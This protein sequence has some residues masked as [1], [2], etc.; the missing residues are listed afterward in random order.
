MLRR[1]RSFHMNAV[2]AGARCRVTTRA[3]RF[4]APKKKAFQ[5]SDDRK[6]YA[7]SRLKPDDA[8]RFKTGKES[9]ISGLGKLRQT[10]ERLE[11]DFPEIRKRP[12]Q[13][14]RELLTELSAQTLFLQEL[15]HDI[16]F[17]V[18]GDEPNYVYWSERWGRRGARMVAAPL[19]IAALL[20][21]QL[22]EKKR[23]I[24]LTSATLS[25]RDAD[26]GDAAG[27]AP[28][29]IRS[30]VVDEEPQWDETPAFGAKIGA[31][32]SSQTPRNQSG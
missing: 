29:P 25:V 19:D 32:F 2:E 24:I 30:R 23:S 9:A 16:E 17:I 27:L 4:G 21:G 12:V 5:N 22:Y 7:S 14:S 13:R 26:A 1:S 10:L 15:I 8:E 18:K 20:H 28:F 11:E 6:R 3:A 31:D